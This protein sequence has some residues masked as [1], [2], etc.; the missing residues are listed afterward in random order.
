MA[1]T[2][3]LT[4]HVPFS[5]P[6]LRAAGYINGVWTSGNATGTFDVLNPAT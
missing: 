5:S 1:F 6:F 3:A 2:T 4:K